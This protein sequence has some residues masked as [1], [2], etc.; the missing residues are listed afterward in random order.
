MTY[1][2]KETTGEKK[3]ERGETR[4][5]REEGRRRNK[6]FIIKAWMWCALESICFLS[7]ELGFNIWSWLLGRG[8]ESLF[9]SCCGLKEVKLNRGHTILF[10][11][12]VEHTLCSLQG[13]TS[14]K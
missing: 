6:G 2:G 3:T 1:K 7:L 13:D 5:C 14:V 11:A 9:K 12:G 10:P 8:K 4:R